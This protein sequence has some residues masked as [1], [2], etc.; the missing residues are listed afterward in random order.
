MGTEPTGDPAVL[1]YGA[2][3][4]GCLLGGL[5]SAVDVDVTLLGRPDLVRAVHDGGLQIHR[6]GGD[7]AASPAAISSLDALTRPPDLVLLTT[8]AYAVAAALDQ[9]DTLARGGAT[10][11]VLQNGV[12][13][14]ETLL[15]RPAVQ[16]LASGAVTLSVGTDAPGRVRQ[17]TT[18]GGVTLAPVRDG[19][20]IGPLVAALT[21]VGILAPVVDDYRALKWSKLLLNIL[22]NAVAAILATPPVELMADP[23]L[24]QLERGAFLE[25]T[26]V[27][28][29][30]GVRTIGLPGFDVPLLAA[31]MRLP[32]GMGRRLLAGRVAG[33]R[34]AKR[35]SLWLDVE[36]GRAPTEVGWLNGAVE[37]AGAAHGIP[38]PTNALLARLVDEVAADPARR[39]ELAGHPERLLELARQSAG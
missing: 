19:S 35:P 13:T 28:R 15:A 32:P 6:P 34:G 18:G 1:V 8:K 11:V 29:A 25:A 5:L 26:R 10:I 24:F 23:R 12:G 38:T 37:R 17:E 4:V 14:E 30:A 39:N 27:M 31:A 33:G 22:G 3:A 7:L 9:L 2:G 36:R 21:R 20:A 16:R